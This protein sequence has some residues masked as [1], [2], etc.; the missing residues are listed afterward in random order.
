M[1]SKYLHS[2]LSP[3]E[4]LC[5]VKVNINVESLQHNKLANAA[6]LTHNLRVKRTKCYHYNLRTLPRITSTQ[7]FYQNKKKKKKK[8]RTGNF[9]LALS[10]LNEFH[11]KSTEIN[12]RRTTILNINE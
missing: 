4:A 8:R 6:I 12:K 7:D 2:A 5:I 1:K 11:H 9:F 3:E 10:N